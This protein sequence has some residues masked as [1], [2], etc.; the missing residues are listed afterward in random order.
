[1]K[2]LADRV[3]PTSLKQFVGQEHL[4]GSGKPIRLLIKHKQPFSMIFWDHQAWEKQR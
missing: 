3:R 1:M 4:V 2:P